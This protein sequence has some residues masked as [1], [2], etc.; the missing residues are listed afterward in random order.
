[1][2]KVKYKFEDTEYMIAKRQSIYDDFHKLMDESVVVSDKL[3]SFIKAHFYKTNGD[4]YEMVQKKDWYSIDTA[5]LFK[6]WYIVE[7][8]LRKVNIFSEEFIQTIF[9]KFH[10]LI[11]SWKK[12]E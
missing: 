8:E 7:K 10:S 11:F 6:E 5:T 3:K 1:M 2:E 12:T 9:G 4:I